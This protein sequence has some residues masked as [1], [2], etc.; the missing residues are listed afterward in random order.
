MGP[1]PDDR[2]TERAILQ[3][4]KVQVFSRNRKSLWGF[5]RTPKTGGPKLVDDVRSHKQDPYEDPM[6]P[7]MLNSLTVLLHAHASAPTGVLRLPP[8]VFRVDGVL[9]NPNEVWGGHP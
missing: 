6:I 3:G 1:E 2:C 8:G 9:M 5:S 7:T 4:Q